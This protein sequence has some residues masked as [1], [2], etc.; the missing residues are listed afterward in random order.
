[1]QVW[2]GITKVTLMRIIKRASGVLEVPA[3]FKGHHAAMVTVRG[4][5]V[6]KRLTRQM[7]WAEIYRE[8]KPIL[9]HSQMTVSFT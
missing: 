2:L 4:G 7:R 6:S 9:N 3:W 8:T 1:M 5:L